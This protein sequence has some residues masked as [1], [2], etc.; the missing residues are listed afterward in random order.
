MNFSDIVQ[1]K[2]IAGLDSFFG[3]FPN[4]HTLCDFCCDVVAE[5]DFWPR[6]KPL[7]AK[8][9]KKI[10]PT[11]K[12]L[13]NN[14]REKSK[15]ITLRVERDKYVAFSDFRIDLNFAPEVEIV[16]GNKTIPTYLNASQKM[17]EKQRGKKHE[18]LLVGFDPQVLYS[19]G[20]LNFYFSMFAGF[21]SGV[22]AHYVL[23]DHL[24]DRM[25]RLEGF[26][27]LGTNEIKF[28]LLGQLSSK[29][30]RLLPFWSGRDNEIIIRSHNGAFL[31]EAVSVD[32]PAGLRDIFFLKTFVAHYQLR[33]DQQRPPLDHILEDSVNNEMARFHHYR[34]PHI[35]PYHQPTDE[36][37]D[38]LKDKLDD[39]YFSS[40]KKRS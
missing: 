36:E 33:L 14:L 11:R 24:I 40:V 18:F 37:F 34:F 23:A 3:M 13:L 1:P 5:K 10:G 17:V 7:A 27:Q 22:M 32:T 38:A 19:H 35:Y 20:P 31:G 26:G 12:M 2:E 16:F 28:Y 8:V 29:R 30:A 4:D 21:L 6:I 15:N 39:Y 9:L 25:K